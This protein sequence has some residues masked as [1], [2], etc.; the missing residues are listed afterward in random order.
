MPARFFHGTIELLFAMKMRHSRRD[1]SG[2]S[3]QPDNCQP[4]P[5]PDVQAML[6]R[7]R[8]EREQLDRRIAALEGATPSE[9][10]TDRSLDCDDSM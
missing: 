7:L 6:T 2:E 4:L 1:H 8:A 3:C 5:D 9:P 10:G